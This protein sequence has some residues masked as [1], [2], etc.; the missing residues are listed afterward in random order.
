MFK[1]S[2]LGI[3]EFIVTLCKSVKFEQSAPTEFFD[4][5]KLLK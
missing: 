3:F 4:L 1:A 5:L 2:Y